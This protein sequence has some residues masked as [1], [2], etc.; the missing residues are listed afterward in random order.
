MTFILPQQNMEC[1]WVCRYRE[2]VNAREDRRKQAAHSGIYCYVDT[3]CPQKTQ[4]I[5][6]AR[7][8]PAGHDSPKA[9]PFS[10]PHAQSNAPGFITSCPHHQRWEIPP[11][12]PCRCFLHPS[13][14]QPF[15]S[16]CEFM[17]EA[18]TQPLALN[19]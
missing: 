19:N 15:S 5:C 14:L 12:L 17:I 8:L 16:A 7:S 10:P 9:E 3:C 4:H 13:N 11:S 2:E 1:T 6:G 18:Q